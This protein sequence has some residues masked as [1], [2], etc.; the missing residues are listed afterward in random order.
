M[1]EFLNN[2]LRDSI[3]SIP[4][5]QAGQ[6]AASLNTKSKLL[7][8][9]SNENPL[10]CALSS[11]ELLSCITQA[12]IY[13]ESNHHP[14]IAALANHHQIDS[15]SLI[16]GNGSDEIFQLLG[17][18]FLNPKD[19]VLSAE[20]TFSVYRSTAIMM[21]ATYQS[22]A[23]SEFGMNCDATLDAITSDTKMIFIANPNNPTGSF[24]SH[25]TLA[26]FLKKV[27]QHV[28]VVIDEAYKE[29]VTI[30]PIDSNLSF[31][32]TYPNVIITRT[33]SKIYGLA[34][35]RLGYGIANT[36]LISYLKKVKLP[37][38]V[39]SIA[40]N[41]A[42]VALTTKQDF[43]THSQHV[44]LEGLALYESTAK[45]WPVTWVP[46]F[47]NFCCLILTEHDVNVAFD[48]CIKHGFI[49]RKLASFGLPQGIRITV[50]SKAVNDRVI[51]CLNSF[52]ESSSAL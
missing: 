13:P 6:S 17:L 39:N 51:S 20:H 8:L 37:F 40:L 4:D 48:H 23:M 28:I 44:N 27:P 45:T 19:S 1:T 49:I 10:G 9:S 35:L 24:L 50:A 15:E 22:I 46:S 21:G 32:N 5:Y 16:L 42:H 11:Q 36:T 25:E 3:A 47:G 34:G 41:A 52:F 38:N 12:E 2:L 33:F 14:L 31:I 26:N 30:E 18:A 43:V 29:Y 7:K